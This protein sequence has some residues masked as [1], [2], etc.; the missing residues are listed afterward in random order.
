MKKH[1]TGL[2]V[3]TLAVLLFAACSGQPTST[4]SANNPTNVTAGTTLSPYVTTSP[5]AMLLTESEAVMIALSHAGFAAEDVTA[6][7]TTFE[8]DDGVAYYEISFIGSTTA[9]EYDI[10][11]E[12]GAILSMDMDHEDARA[13]TA[14]PAITAQQ[15]QDAALAHAGL[16]AAQVTGLRSEYDGDER[17]PHYD[18]SFYNGNY[19]Y[20][21]EIDAATGDVISHEKD[22]E[23]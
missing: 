23:D 5:N 9:Y 7:H 14:A 13:T 20:D 21:Y 4:P 19:E 8:V 6:L 22:R 16:D 15:A 2:L 12:S 11:A 18:V 3:L 1:I 10:H 17:R